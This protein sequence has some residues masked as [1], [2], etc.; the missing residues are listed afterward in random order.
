M[1]VHDVDNFIHAKL[2][3]FAGQSGVGK[4]SLVNALF[5]G[6]ERKTQEVSAKYN[7]G[8]HTTTMAELLIRQDGTKIVDTPGVRRLALRSI[9]SE[10]LGS[11]F[12]EIF[13]Q[14]AFCK[15]GAKCTHTGE[16]GC[17]IPDAVAQGTINL[18]RYES[19]LRIFE[20]LARAQ[21]WKRKQDGALGRESV[22][23]KEWARRSG[24]K[25]YRDHGTGQASL[26]DIDGYSDYDE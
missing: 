16:E 20:E 19:Y 12:P 7:R 15:L 26:D 5:P 17:S 3:V 22:G 18:D 24:G 13:S 11:C 9:P 23:R 14:G 2:S 4:S 1:G 10:A 21:T 25:S 8:K 6:I